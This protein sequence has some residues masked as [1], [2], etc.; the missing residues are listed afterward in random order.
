[1]KNKLTAMLGELLD[2]HREGGRCDYEDRERLWYRAEKL[3]NKAT[4]EKVTVSKEKLGAVL[5]A[6][7]DMVSYAE[8]GEG[9]G[10]EERVEKASAALAAF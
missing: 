7:G 1:M 3:Y 6:L 8:A 9:D 5:E 10:I 2:D 4:E